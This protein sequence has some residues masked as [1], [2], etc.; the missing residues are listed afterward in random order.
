[1][2]SK[3]MSIAIHIQNGQRTHSQDQEA[4]GW[5]D[6]SFKMTK[7]IPMTAKQPRL[8]DD[9]D[10]VDIDFFS[11]NEI[12]SKMLLVVNC[13]QDARLASR[14]KRTQNKAG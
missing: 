12:I 5:I 11:P 10:F 4:T 8:L 9:V 7:T 2:S 14:V 6:N 13:S 3:T 1:M